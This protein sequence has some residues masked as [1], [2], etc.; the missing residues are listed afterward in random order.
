MPL[1]F[2]AVLAIAQGQQLGNLSAGEIA[3]AAAVGVAEVSPNTSKFGTLQGGTNKW[4][5]IALSPQ[6]NLLFCSPYNADS[7][8][9]LDPLTGSADN[10]SLRGL[11]PGVQGKWHSM[12]FAPVTG[13]LYVDHPARVLHSRGADWSVCQS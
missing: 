7:V 6:N 5:G 12:A 10:T 2:A 1:L 11:L 9:I 3:F 8:L 13:K 4:R